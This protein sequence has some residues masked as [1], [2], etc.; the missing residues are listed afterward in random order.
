MKKILVLLSACLIIVALFFVKIKANYSL[1]GEYN[2]FSVTYSG[3]REIFTEIEFK[4]I[5]HYSDKPDFELITCYQDWYWYCNIKYTK[6][7]NVT[8]DNLKSSKDAQQTC[9]YQSDLTCSIKE[10]TT[11]VYK[12]HLIFSFIKEF[13]IKISEIYFYHFHFIYK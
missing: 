13:P 8:T 1:L 7:I 3:P 9:N 4:E 6:I 12:V 10:Y 11:Y 5:L 2:Q